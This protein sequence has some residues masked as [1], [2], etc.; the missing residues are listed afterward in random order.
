MQ[1]DDEE[2]EKRT[3]EEVSDWEKVAGPDLFGM[4]A[5][6]DLPILATWSSRTYLSHIF[7]D[8]AFADVK[9]QLE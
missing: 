4:V 7:L 8:C 5:Q 1:F 3:E 6:E 2:S 9:A